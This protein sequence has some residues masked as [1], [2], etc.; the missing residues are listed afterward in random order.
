MP[1]KKDIE[2]EGGEMKKIIDYLMPEEIKIIK[3]LSGL[4]KKER[5]KILGGIITD[6]LFIMGAGIFLIVGS[7][8]LIMKDNWLA[9]GIIF[10]GLILYL[11]LF[12]PQEEGK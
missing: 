9:Y 12:K 2:G 3:V 4:K 7:Y 10:L 11:I 5:R 6:G 8:Y 1:S